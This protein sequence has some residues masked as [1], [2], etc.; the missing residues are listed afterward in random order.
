MVAVDSK[1]L[2]IS[3]G[4]THGKGYRIEKLYQKIGGWYINIRVGEE[5]RSLPL[6]MFVK[7]SESNDILKDML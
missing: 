7:F 5:Y 4:L 2:A 3:V 6:A 1:V